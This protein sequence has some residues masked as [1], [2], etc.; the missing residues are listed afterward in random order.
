M[1]GSEQEVGVE[2]EREATGLCEGEAEKEERRTQKRRGEQ[3]SKTSFRWFFRESPFVRF[4]EAPC[5]LK[6]MGRGAA[7][8][9]LGTPSFERSMTQA[10]SSFSID[11][12]PQ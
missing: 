8:G 2:K 3:E 12:D 5:L 11:P 9:R 4:H 10:K 6:C 1:E 7:G